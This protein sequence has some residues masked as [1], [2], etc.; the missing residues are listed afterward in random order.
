[1]E[2][3]TSWLLYFVFALVLFVMYL[4]I[5]RR[6]LSPVVVS[7]VGVLLSIVLMTLVGAA[8]GNNA[9]QALFAGVLVGG[10]FSISTLAMAYYFVR[11]EERRRGRG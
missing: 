11:A 4:A 6:W 2:N 10:L 7:A 8:Q 3:A 5:R 9:Y 1:M